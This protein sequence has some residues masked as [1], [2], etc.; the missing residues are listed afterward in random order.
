MQAQTK[1]P[2]EML[3]FSENNTVRK[4][5]LSSAVH[6]HK[7]SAALLI[8]WTQNPNQDSSW[9]IQHTLLCSLQYIGVPQVERDLFHSNV[10]YFKDW[11]Y[12][13]I[14]KNNF[15]FNLGAVLDDQFF[16]KHPF[17]AVVEK[18]HEGSREVAPWHVSLRLQ[19]QAGPSSTPQPWIWVYL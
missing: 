3:F 19:V 6:Q 18:V 16:A 11:I 1:P 17:A 2:A 5:T 13:F 12:I 7:F 14:Y 8:I 15:V 4:K 10:Q 9:N